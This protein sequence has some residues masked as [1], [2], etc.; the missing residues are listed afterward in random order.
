MSLA[1]M[2]SAGSGAFAIPP[3]PDQDVSA[4]VRHVL[5][6]ALRLPFTL[7]LCA[8]LVLPGCSSLGGGEPDDPSDA[9]RPERAA[10]RST[11][12]FFAQ[13]IIAGAA[14]GALAGGFIG[15]VAGGNARSAAFGALAGGALGAAGGYWRA[16]QR[17]YTDQAQLYQAV[18]GDIER[19]NLS[20]DKTQFAF[21]RLVACRN[22]EAASIRADLGEGR[23]SRDQAA[24]TMARIRAHSESDLRLARSIGDRIQQ[25]SSD[26]TYASE[27][28]QAAP[29]PQYASPS[30]APTSRSLTAPAA[31]GTV[32]TQVQ[33]ASSTNLAKRDQ[34]QQSITRARGDQT[35]FE[36]S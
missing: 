7:A 4:T 16:R 18:Y 11:G 8:A 22:N 17:Q 9:C 30:Y 33:A 21:D 25:R 23:I 2:L 6:R 13:D 20:I 14:V 5:R 19:E 10:L 12:E 3:S 24:A 15:L 1:T 36:L 31:G 35:G 26:F 32:A 29:A 34:F 28:V 27:Q